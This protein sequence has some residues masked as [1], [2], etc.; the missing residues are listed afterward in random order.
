MEDKF[1]GMGVAMVT[2][3]NEDHQIDW[4]SLKALTEFLIANK[5][6][7]LVVQGTTGETPTLSK[8]EKR[9][10]LSFIQE[11]NQ[12][13]IPVVLGMGGYDTRELENELRSWNFE[14]IDAIL[15]VTPYYNKP[16]QKGIY[17]HY[18]KVAEASPVPIIMY[19]VPSRTG[20]NMDW[21]TT[22]KL[23]NDFDNIIAV[24]EASGDMIQIM[25][26]VQNRPENFLVISGD[27]AITLPI[28][29]SGGDG[30]ISV[31][32]NAFP[33]EFSDMVKHALAGNIDNA[34]MAH[35]SLLQIIQAIFEEGNP[36]GI[37]EILA[38][39]NICSPYLRLPLVQVSKKLSEKLR[40]LMD[41]FSLVI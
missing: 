7:Y 5:T 9:E 12:E 33:E 30:V 31:I 1:R 39:K 21:K 27:D 3:F 29:S 34:R 16:N 2:P 19:N 15:S 37:K 24:K 6:N 11:V 4:K 18:K 38:N 17:H 40:T 26:I 13:R 25:N 8:S 22:L 10:L 32:G 20:V 36:A 41:E 23:A 28:L 35:Y 14:G